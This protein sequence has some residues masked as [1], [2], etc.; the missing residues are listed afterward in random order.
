MNISKFD[1][2]VILGVVIMSVLAAAASRANSARLTPAT[3]STESASYRE[4]A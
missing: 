3:A 4:F 1:S 2:T